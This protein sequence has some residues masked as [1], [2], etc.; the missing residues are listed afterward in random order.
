LSD[1]IDGQI[2]MVTGHISNM[3]W[4]TRVAALTVAGSLC[5]T[6]Y[7]GFLMYQKV[8]EIAGLDISAYQQQ[9]E[10]MNTKVTEAI[11]YARDIK[12]GL[13]DD[14]LS[15]EKQADRIEDSVRENEN[16]V[17]DTEDKVREMIDQA[18]VR[19][20]ERREQLRSNQAREIKDLEER[21]TSK[22]QRAL[23]NPLSD[24]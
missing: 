8:E 7:G 13:R 4:G 18:D 19:F 17:R 23:D 1:D 21:I 6:L 24:Q 12:T 9:M 22:L 20:E 11:D 2:K 5:G 10:I 15:I 16:L 3:S 14:I